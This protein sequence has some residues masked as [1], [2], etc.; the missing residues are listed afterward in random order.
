MSFLTSIIIILLVV[1]ILT[2][3]QLSTG[4]FSIF[5]H[6]STAKH[7]RKKA[8]DLSLDFILGTESFHTF[9]WFF[10]YVITFSIV[11]FI[12]TSLYY[13]LG[14]LFIVIFVLESIA[15]LFFYYRKGESSALFIPRSISYGLINHCIHTKKRSD[16]FLVGFVSCIPE[17][18]FTL[19]LFFTINY[20]FLYSPSFAYVFTMIIIILL[21]TIPLHII[22][23]I[24][25]TNHNLANIERLRIK[26]KPLFRIVVPLSYILLAIA[27]FLII[28]DNIYG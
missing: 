27:V 16:A 10:T 20:L 23:V 28:K 22:R 19:P 8:D 6:Y 5:Y 1:V 4:V 2:F 24:Y 13:I 25:R 18:L 3:M 26:F 14:W 7:S 21:A 15:T 9:I 12:Q 11:P 17:L